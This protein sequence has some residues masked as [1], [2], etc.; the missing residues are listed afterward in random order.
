MH[1]L[2][3]FLFA[4]SAN[5]DS[6]TVGISYGI[7]KMKISPLS[8][9]LI[10]LIA[11]TG[12][13]LSMLLG[14]F[15]IKFMSENTANI[16]GSVS[17]ILMGIWFI[18]DASIKEHCERNKKLC[19]AENNLLPY[20]NL[21]DNPEIVD[22]DN[23]GYIDVKESIFLAFALTINN[24][25]VG[26]GASITGI[27]IF[28]AT[29]FTLILSTIGL[30]AGCIIGNSYLSKFF[31]KFAPFISGISIIILGIYELIS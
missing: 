5:I 30:L 19:N 21:L 6:F 27:N 4:L 24:V 31:G 2:P 18:I 14:K 25:G 15:I 8:T 16:I 13:F 26:I 22:I 7:K 28:L 20:K 9:I 10:A 29:I 12:T 11:T 23:S 3:S 1:L 17:L